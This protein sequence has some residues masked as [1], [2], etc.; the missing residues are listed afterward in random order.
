MVIVQSKMIQTVWWDFKSA[1]HEPVATNISEVTKIP[2][3]W[4]EILV[5][6]KQ[7]NNYIPQIPPVKLLLNVYHS[8]CRNLIFHLRL[9]YSRCTVDVSQHEITLCLMIP[10]SV[11]ALDVPLLC[12][13]P[14]VPHFNGHSGNNTVSFIW[15]FQLCHVFTKLS[16]AEAN[17]QSQT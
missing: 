8:S 6:I 1:L 13:H 12:Q 17:L 7:K 10:V 15:S 14:F 2:P 3:Q 5:N 9:L 4:C 11:P 16:R